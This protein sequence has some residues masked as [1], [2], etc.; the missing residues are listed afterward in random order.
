MNSMLDSLKCCLKFKTGKCYKTCIREIKEEIH[1]LTNENIEINQ[2]IIC[3]KE[4]VKENVLSNEILTFDKEKNIKRKRI[5]MPCIDNSAGYKK[6]SY[7]V[8]EC[9]SEFDK[10]VLKHS[11]LLKEVLNNQYKYNNIVNVVLDIKTYLKENDN[12]EKV[13]INFKEDKNKDL[14]CILYDFSK[15]NV[16]K[17]SMPDLVGLFG[18]YRFNHNK[19]KMLLDYSNACGH[20]EIVDF[21]TGKPWCGHASFALECLDDIVKIVDTLIQEYNDSVENKELHVNKIRKI[22]G[23]IGPDTGLMTSVRLVE[24]YRKRG[25]YSEKGFG[26]VI[27]Y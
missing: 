14:I 13:Y 21:F 9:K 16:N 7:K 19:L 23:R 5:F 11:E 15:F 1:F 12:V 2:K 25:F 3:F 24:F 26:K 27:R 4:L 20:L 18:E 22:T 17:N 6:C 10:L 8:D